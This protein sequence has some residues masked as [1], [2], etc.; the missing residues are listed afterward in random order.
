MKLTEEQDEVM[1]GIV[2]DLETLCTG[3]DIGTKEVLFAA[4]TINL[5]HSVK[6]RLE[7]LWEEIAYGKS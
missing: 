2:S 3:I 7:A 4:Q 1:N 5:T 6:K